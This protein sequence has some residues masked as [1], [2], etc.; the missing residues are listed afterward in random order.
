MRYE[1][2]M[3]MSFCCDATL[4][5]EKQ[6]RVQNMA[7]LCKT[8]YEMLFKHGNYENHLLFRLDGN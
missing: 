7:L 1:F 6:C 3:M 2:A 5:T 4:L 8:V